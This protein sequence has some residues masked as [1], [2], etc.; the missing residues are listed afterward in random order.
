ME[1]T[2]ARK[3]LSQ[4]ETEL[5]EFL[6]R[7]NDKLQEMVWSDSYEKRVHAKEFLNA[8]ML[9]LHNG[10][11]VVSLLDALACMEWLK[12]NTEMK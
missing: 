1:Y 9:Y 2:E 11:S 10:W 5:A 4:L 7:N 6:E 12:N 3:K 8:Q